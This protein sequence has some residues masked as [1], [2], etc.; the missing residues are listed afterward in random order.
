[1]HLYRRRARTPL[2][3]TALLSTIAALGLLA[4]AGPVMA[5]EWNRF[6]RWGFRDMFPGS[7]FQV[8]VTN[9]SDEARDVAIACRIRAFY[10]R[11]GL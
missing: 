7:L 2:R 3:R 1:M 4:T 8:T 9:T 11:G 5:H 6:G 10:G